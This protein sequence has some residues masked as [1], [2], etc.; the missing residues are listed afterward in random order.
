[1]KLKDLFLNIKYYIYFIWRL[2]DPNIHIEPYCVSAN[3]VLNG[4]KSGG[5]QSERVIPEKP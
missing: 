4:F 1:M 2:A 5:I 3:R